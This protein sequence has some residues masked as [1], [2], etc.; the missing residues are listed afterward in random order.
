MA[1][2][3]AFGDFFTLSFIFLIRIEKILFLTI[4]QRPHVVRKAHIISLESSRTYQIELWR[5]W[6]HISFFSIC[7]K[8]NK[9]VEK[10]FVC[11]KKQEVQYFQKLKLWKLIVNYSL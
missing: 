2:E 10:G 1:L 5:S 9:K 4:Q 7:K 11:E 6:A 8:K 3:L